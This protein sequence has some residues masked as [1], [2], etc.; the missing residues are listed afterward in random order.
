M[1]SD[2]YPSGYEALTSVRTALESIIEIRQQAGDED[3]HLLELPEQTG[4][5]GEDWHPTVATHQ[6][7]ADRLVALVEELSAL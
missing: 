3:V 7:M 2:G 1:L 4:P 6:D 5:Y